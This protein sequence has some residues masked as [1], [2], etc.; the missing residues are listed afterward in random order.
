MCP[1]ITVYTLYEHEEGG[2]A[3]QAFYMRLN[4]DDS[5]V[6]AMDMLVPRVGE[7]IGGSQ[8]EDRAD[9]RIV[10]ILFHLERLIWIVN[11]SPLN[12]GFV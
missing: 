4:D 8:R 12:I 6:A 3:L 10:Y 7:L 5:T 11:V 9:V 2:G 1:E